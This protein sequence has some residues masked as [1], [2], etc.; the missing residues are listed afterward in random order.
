VVL[1]LALVAGVLVVAAVL[2][3]RTCLAGLRRFVRTLWPHS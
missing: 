3:V 2:L 1:K